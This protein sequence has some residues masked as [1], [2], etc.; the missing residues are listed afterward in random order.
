MREGEW[1]LCERNGWPDNQSFI[2][3]VAWCWRKGEDRRLIVVNFSPHRS[4]GLIRMP[5][6]DMEG[7][8][9]RLND[10]LSGDTYERDGGG[11]V[12][13]GMYVDLDGW[14]FHFFDMT[15]M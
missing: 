11:I 2:N 6:S 15:P 9:L 4:Q 8:S 10:L 14:A 5:W 1:H 13:P 12:N 3:M 7:R